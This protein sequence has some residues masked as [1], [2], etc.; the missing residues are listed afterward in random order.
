MD[1]RFT[2]ESL[3]EFSQEISDRYGLD[4]SEVEDMVMDF[5]RCQRPDGSVY[6]TSGQC[7]KGKEVGDKD[8]VGKDGK[9]KKKRKARFESTD[10]VKD[11]LKKI[12]YETVDAKKGHYERQWPGGP[13]S[14]II[15]PDSKLVDWANANPGDLVMPQ[16]V[17]DQ[18]KK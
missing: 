1:G 7:R 2:E 4:Y 8:V 6:G 13:R 16:W 17:K 15:V 18:N 3:I 5:A 9:V 12:G 11:R 10:Q 14:T